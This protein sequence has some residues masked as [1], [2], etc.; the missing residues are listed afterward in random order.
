M[1][2]NRA[3]LHSLAGAYAL[4]A[5]AEAD[6]A[7]FE[8][9]LAGCEQCRQEIR[10][11]REAAARVGASAAV[12]PRA[13]LRDQAMRAASRTRQLPPRRN[14]EHPGGWG[15]HA[16]AARGRGM[17][18]RRPGTWPRWSPWLTRG[19]TGLA[20]VVAAVAVAMGLLV[21][22]TQHRLR[23]VQSSRDQ[24]AAVLDAPDVQL[25]TARMTAGGQAHVLE[26]R[27]LR[28]FVFTAAGLPVLPAAKGYEL[29]LIGPAG[30]RPAG[31]LPR[32]KAGTAGPVVVSGLARG[33]HLGVTVEPV[34]GAARPT[35]GP[36]LTLRLLS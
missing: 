13:G 18:G 28:A 36:V 21:A 4:D 12:R 3:E 22:S 10:G 15:R 30:T 11:F 33:D 27:H 2:R 35:S 17:P 1:R 19:V 8:R 5:L 26:S 29:W 34:A 20:A 24:L 7:R 9:H 25:L 23:E 14:G 31:V 32:P 6:H 16:A